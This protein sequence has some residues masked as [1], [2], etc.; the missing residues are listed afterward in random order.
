MTSETEQEVP[1]TPVD[2]K[3]FGSAATLPMRRVFR[4]TSNGEEGPLSLL[5]IKAGEVFRMEPPIEDPDDFSCPTGW[6]IAKSNGFIAEYGIPG[7]MFDENRED[8]EIVLSAPT[9]DGHD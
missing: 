4:R 6:L 5:R 1:I 2:M 8:L 7:I 9:L 3:P